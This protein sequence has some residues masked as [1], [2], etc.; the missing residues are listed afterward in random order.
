MKLHPE[1]PRLT[2]WLLGELSAEDAASVERAVA[3]DPALRLAVAEL[4]KTQRF[5]VDTLSPGKADLLPRQ[6]D[7]IL[8]AAR[9]ADRGQSV[10]PEITPRKKPMP[11]LFPLAAA[12]VLTVAAISLLNLPS[13]EPKTAKP[14]SSD[15][16]ADGTMPMEVA[17]MPAPGPPDAGRSTEGPRPTASNGLN[18]AADARARLLEENGDL[19]LRKVAER[20]AESPVPAENALPPLIRRS[21]VSAID[22]PELALPVHAGRS[23]LAWI[24][25]SIRG[26]KKRPPAN[27]VRL[28]EILNHFSL[29]PA[30]PASVS[31]GVTLS[32]E[33]IACPWKPSSTL[34]L[35]SFRGAADTAR[36]VTA[37]F[38]AN[39]ASIRRYRLLG[40]APVSGQSDS[41]LP[42]R[43]PAKSITSLVI[44]IEP[45]APAPN[46]GAI[47]WTV[48]GQ[49]AP[50]VALVR[51]SDAEPSND[52]RFAALVCTFSQWLTAEAGSTIDAELLSALARECASD[53]LPADRADF[54]NL[55]DQTLGL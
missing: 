55:I 49:P 12:A 5:L 20:L 41:T 47:E 15:T 4:E 8:Q 17:L 7:L 19:Y 35:V 2:A 29:R 40:F 46:L 37:T 51:Q 13:S 43:L 53:T 33:T 9:E 18:A 16:P 27:A 14:N 6:R 28:E 36:E 22:H 52:A 45:A 31:R 30:G 24:T 34:L 48:G 54:L 11:W 32:S 39:P 1:D 21:S 44:E 25:R 42:S 23:S 10:S 26:E 50:P 38:K 3:A